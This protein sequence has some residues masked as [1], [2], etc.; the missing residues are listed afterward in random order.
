MLVAGRRTIGFSLAVSATT[1]PNTIAMEGFRAVKYAFAGR[2]PKVALAGCRYRTEAWRGAIP[3]KPA[4]RRFDCA[5]A[6]GTCLG[7][8]GACH[9]A[10]EPPG[11]PAAEQRT[12]APAADESIA[13]ALRRVDAER[14]QEE[15]GLLRLPGITVRELAVQAP[16]GAAGPG[17][18][19]AELRTR[20]QNFDVAAGV[21]AEQRDTVLEPAEWSGRFG[22]ANEHAAGREAFELRTTLGSR[23]TGGV[24]GV[25]VGPR[26]ERRLRRGAT[27]FID[28]RA[29][30]A[31]P[32]PEQGWWSLPGA[33]GDGSTTVGVTAR[34]GIAR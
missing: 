10:A 1:V 15:V 18:L 30:A 28:G 9:A 32:R 17:P 29:A 7:L 33:A 21:R 11:P 19:S 31:A 12:P 20:I 24:L 22:V 2:R 16:G 6:I 8:L 25:E 14:T 4:M 27:F 23:E 5:L 13:E 34:T 3:G 26:F